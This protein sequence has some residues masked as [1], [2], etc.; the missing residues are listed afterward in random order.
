M[1]H[2]G[3]GRPTKTATEEFEE[4]ARHSY[5][6]NYREASVIIFIF[7]LY[8]NIDFMPWILELLQHY[9]YLSCIV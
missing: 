6:I 7:L 9:N 2:P 5:N 8:N 1:Y 4:N 3:E